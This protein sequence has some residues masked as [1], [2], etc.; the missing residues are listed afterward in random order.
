M[1]S[2]AIVRDDV[3]T[4]MDS[5]KGRLVLALARGSLSED[6]FIAQFGANPRTTPD[7]VRIELEQAF[8][9]KSADSVEY[10]LVL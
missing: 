9:E 5:A 7:I 3:G 10:A 8:A 2:T 1:A 4:K 6:A